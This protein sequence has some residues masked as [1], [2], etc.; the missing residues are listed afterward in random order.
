MINMFPLE[1]LELIFDKLIIKDIKELYNRYNDWIEL[2]VYQY[3]FC[4]DIKKIIIRKMKMLIDNMKT[5]YN[6][7]SIDSKSYR[8]IDRYINY[9]IDNYHMIYDNNKYMKFMLKK[10]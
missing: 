7:K 8:I 2:L 6:C 4:N 9:Y 3:S 1:I 10:Y 5:L